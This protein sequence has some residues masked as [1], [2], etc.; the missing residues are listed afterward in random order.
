MKS[1][2]I[3]CKVCGNKMQLYNSLRPYCSYDCGAKYAVR[4]QKNVSD[5]EWRDK[6]KV[7]IEKLKTL[8]EWKKDLQ[9][10]INTIVRLIDF[11][12]PC[13]A[14]GSVTGKRNAGHYWSVGSNDTIRFHLDNIHIQSEYSNSF[15]SGDTLNYQNGIIEIY[16]QTYLDS[17]NALKSHP[18]IKLSINDVRARIAVARNIIRFQLN[19]QK[20]F[21]PKE[22]IELR[23]NFNKQLAIYKSL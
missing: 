19:E 18:I 23:K 6:K 17:M 11:G 22:R 20:M 9:T 1:K 14:T 3:N 16:G 13:I 12:Q 2:I 21:T 15:K 4:L 7:M 8:S 5:K 10:E